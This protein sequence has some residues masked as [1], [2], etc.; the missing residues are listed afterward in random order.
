MKNFT[1]NYFF[2]PIVKNFFYK[3]LAVI[4]SIFCYKLKVGNQPLLLTFLSTVLFLGVFENGFSQSI[5][6]T[7]SIGR[8]FNCAPTGWV[9]LTGTPDVS[10]RNNAANVGI[11]GGNATWVLAPLPLPPNAHNT[12]ISIRDLGAVA[13]EEAVG[14]TITGLTA[15]RN[16]QLVVYTMSVLSN[17]NG[18]GAPN[19]TDPAWRYSGTFI[20]QIRYR[21]NGTSI[22]SISPITQNTW[23]TTRIPFTATSNTLTLDL[24]PGTNSAAA[25]SPAGSAGIETVQVAVTLNAINTVPV[26][27]NDSG[28]TSILNSPVTF[29][30]V[31]N[32]VDFDVVGGTNPVYSGINATTVDLNPAVAGIQNTFTSPNGVWTVN[33][34]GIVTFT[35]NAGFV[36]TDTIP[37]NVRDGFV[38]DTIST[39]ATSNNA[40]LSATIAPVADL[41]VTKSINNSTPQFGSNVVFTITVNNNGSSAATGVV[42]NDLLPNGYTFVNAAPSIGTY[43]SVSGVWT[44]GTLANA[45]NATLT[46]TAQ[47]RPTGNYLNSATVSSDFTDSNNGNNSASAGASPVCNVTIAPSLIK[48]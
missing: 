28:S 47:V 22:F 15:G 26:A 27:S 18:G 23:G 5:P 21:I 1:F 38:I 24:L 14:T 25:N 48:N 2:N 31:T 45:A 7:N 46:L 29:N 36:G 32:D 35:P 39:P 4:C 9:D 17:Q 19:V 30:A 16:Y 34:S 44:V 37:Y 6:A 40:T 11:G 8:C 12:W 20:D 42:V 13:A 41:S 43:N 10:D 33:S 3:K